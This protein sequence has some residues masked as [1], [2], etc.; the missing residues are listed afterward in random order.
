MEGLSYLALRSRVFP[1]RSQRPVRLAA[2]GCSSVAKVMDDLAERL[3]E[4]F[5][6]VT[7]IG[8]YA[9]IPDQALDPWQIGPRHRLE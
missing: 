9:E 6:A 3:D 2:G 8:R 7:E 5:F 4:V 1:V